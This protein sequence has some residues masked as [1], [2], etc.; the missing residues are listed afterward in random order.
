MKSVDS[1]CFGQRLF[2]ALDVK[3]SR[4]DVHRET[5]GRACDSSLDDGTDDFDESCHD[6]FPYFPEVLAALIEYF[7]RGHRSP[8]ALS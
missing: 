4:P 6:R 7:Q 5:A 3:L 2:Q 1:A 8:V